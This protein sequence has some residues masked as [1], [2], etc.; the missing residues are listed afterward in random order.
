[1]CGVS[2]DLSVLFEGVVVVGQ[3][4]SAKNVCCGFGC[5]FALRGHSEVILGTER[6][7]YFCVVCINCHP[8][9]IVHASPHVSM[10]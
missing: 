7:L 6:V 3:Y 5:R 8:S 4:F 9:Y 2:F 10:Y 1:M